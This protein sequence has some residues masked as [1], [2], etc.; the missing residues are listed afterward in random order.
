MHIIQE[1]IGIPKITLASW[2]DN[3]AVFTI[4]PLPFWYWMTLWNW[5]R[6]VLLSSLPWTAITWIKIKWASHEYATIDWIKDSVLDII[7]NLKWVYFKKHD[8]DRTILKIVKK[9]EWDITAWDILCPNE[10]EILNPDYVITHVSDKD[11]TF[12]MDIIIEKWVWYRPAL[13]VKDAEDLSDYIFIDAT[14]SPV[15]KV[16]YDIK[17]ARVWDMTNL[18]DLELEIETNWAMNAHDALRF[19]STLLKSYFELFILES[20]PVEPDFVADHTRCW[21]IESE[22][23]EKEAYT[24]IEILNLSPR[25]LNALINADIWSI[26]QL[27]KCSQAKLSTLR[28]FGRKAMTEVLDALGKRTLKLLWD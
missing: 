16:K 25:T 11:V 4:S 6:R 12:E 24:P 14:F 8:I 17:P 13:S 22:E 3:H 20:E 1:K 21:M 23:E 18:D 28:G 27:T 7:L 9:W 10:I 5:L 15:L 26:E 19:W 2:W